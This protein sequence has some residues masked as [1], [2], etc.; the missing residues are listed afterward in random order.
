[1]RIS[2][3][4]SDVCSSDLRL[5]RDLL[6]GGEDAERDREIKARA[7]L[8]QISRR[9]IAGDALQ[10]KAI[11]AVADRGPHAILGLAHGGFRQTHDV[12]AG[13]TRREMDLD[14]ERTSVV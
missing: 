7:V 5:T 9:Q 12:E 11:A 2:D 8:G 14:G 6:G 3:W 13:T 10:R 4:S 1:M